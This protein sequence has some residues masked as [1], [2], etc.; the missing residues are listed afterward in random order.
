M[1][2]ECGSWNLNWIQNEKVHQ[3]FIEAYV[4]HMWPLISFMR[5][6]FVSIYQEKIS[7]WQ[8]VDGLI[9]HSFSICQKEKDLRLSSLGDKKK[10]RKWWREIK[11][12][13]NWYLNTKNINNGLS[14]HKDR[15][16]N[17]F[18]CNHLRNGREREL[19][20]EQRRINYVL[21]WF[22]GEQL[23]VSGWI[24]E[25]KQRM[26]IFGD[27]STLEKPYQLS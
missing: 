18:K 24:S 23:N 19:S 13:E 12:T 21:K 3:L 8:L 17:N 4:M 5:L 15:K 25:H 20:K 16:K 9:H 6:Y 2:D 10:E 26:Y 22:N 27:C 1:D 7:L 11:T 14:T